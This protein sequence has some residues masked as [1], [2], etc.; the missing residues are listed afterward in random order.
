MTNS[1]VRHQ[2]GSAGR[3]ALAERWTAA[4]IQLS[5]PAR[6]RDVIETELAELTGALIAA[7][8]LPNPGLARTVGA[9]L[10][11]AGYREPIALHR[12]LIVLSDGLPVLP[13]VAGTPSIASR[14]FEMFA[15][16][17]EGFT[18]ALRH[19]LFE[20]QD[21]IRAVLGR[22]VEVAE[23]AQRA[24][25]AGFREVFNAAPAG[26]A[27]SSL[28]GRLLDANAALVG[29]LGH[30][31]SDE[32]ATYSV[33]ELFEPADRDR[34]RHR[35]QLLADGTIPRFREGCRL[36]GRGADTR[37]AIV[38]VT[39][40]K[41]G[42]GPDRFVTMVEDITE[43]RLLQNQ[44]SHQLVHDMTTGLVNRQGFIRQLD[45]ALAR[46]DRPEL[47]VFH[48]DLD[49]FAVLNDGLGHNVG[50]ELLV[51]VAAHLN[52]IFAG[53]RVVISRIGSDE[54]AVLLEHGPRTADIADLAA[55]INNTL[56]E[57]TY[58]GS[59]DGVGVTAS[60]GIVPIRP[61][62][63]SEVTSSAAEVMRAADSALRR[64]RATG[65]G[66][67]SL[68]DKAADARDR[69]RFALAAALP[70]AFESGEV[71]VGYEQVVAL[72][73]GRIV[74]R[75]PVL[76]WEHPTYGLL[77]NDTCQDAAAHIGLSLRMGRWL[78][79][80]AI[81]DFPAEPGVM[82]VIPL[83]T[84]MATDPDLVGNV[85]R[86][87]DATG[88]PRAAVR[89][90]FPVGSVRHPEAED[91]LT[92][93]VNAG[94]SVLLKDWTPEHSHIAALESL[95][96]K[97]IAISPELVAQLAINPTP[98]LVDTVAIALRHL[99]ERKI[100]ITVP[101]VETPEQAAWWRQ[102]GATAACGP[103]FGQP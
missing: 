88:L 47:S 66:Q 10:V 99:H 54:F 45:R 29:T 26:M 24:T 101:T 2:S 97:A 90:A 40:I 39:M 4:L 81:R 102:H 71:T 63:T 41:D 12:S 13:E 67:W 34:M 79:D 83:S 1:V 32:L 46:R 6:S 51:T 74:A 19:D 78:L 89:L 27:I 52:Q 14:L 93:L 56:A 73:A 60:I 103:L 55:E 76:R 100:A 91:N 37:W 95:P 21:T 11:A 72:A 28:D 22:A 25:E 70:G 16:L 75:R 53:E 77:R 86:R 15:A 31:S 92:T 68:Y 23:R 3:Y 87:V 58:L 57:P 5:D 44:M 69:A 18:E 94:F 59:G 65:E 35:Y 61:G 20:Q 38:G 30:P 96:V 36:T 98:L 49:H 80:T 17:A 62:D 33:F 9:A 43:L 50:Q 84:P 48:L 82:L 85:T 7:V 42:N 64:V 8:R